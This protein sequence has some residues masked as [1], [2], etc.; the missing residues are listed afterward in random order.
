MLFRSERGELRAQLAAVT[1]E[2][3]EL[4]AQTAAMTAER[5]QLR[6]QLDQLRAQL[7]NDWQP[8]YGAAELRAQQATASVEPSGDS[9][10]LPETY[11]WQVGDELSRDGVVTEIIDLDVAG[12]FR[13]KGDTIWNYW[14]GELE[15]FGWSLHRKASEIA[16]E[17]PSVTSGEGQS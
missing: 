10:Q 12:R 11:L 3:D 7:A 5:D 2:R 4:R 15:Q 17:Q 9:G 14:Q 1:A 16:A 6:A 8:L 13:L